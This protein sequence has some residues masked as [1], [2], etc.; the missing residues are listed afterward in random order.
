MTP[1]QR[2]KIERVAAGVPFDGPEATR[3]W[4]ATLPDEEREVAE[5]LYRRL[6]QAA[7]RDGLI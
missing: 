7:R 2:K 6:A 5:A 3:A 4:L 1:E